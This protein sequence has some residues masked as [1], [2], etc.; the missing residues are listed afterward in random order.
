MITGKDTPTDVQQ[1]LKEL[2]TQSQKQAHTQFT[3][4]PLA[5]EVPEGGLV[6]ATISGT[7][8]L[9][10]KVNGALKRTTMT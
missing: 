4:A 3:R 5:N 9:Y 6:L 7:V 2:E 8:Y 1:A 10:T